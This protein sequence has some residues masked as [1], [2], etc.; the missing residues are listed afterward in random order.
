MLQRGLMMDRPLLISAIIEHAAAQFGDTTIVSRETHGPIFR[1]TYAECAVRVRRLGERA[2]A[3]RLGCRRLGGIHSVEQSSPFG[4]LLRGLRQRHGDAH[5]Q[6][7]PASGPTDL[8]HQPCRRPGGAVRR[9][10]RAPGEGNCRPLP[11]RSCLGGLER[12]GEH[13][14][15]RRHAQYSLLRRI[16]RR[17]KRG[18]RMA[19]IR[20]T[21]RRRALLHLGNDRES[22]GRPVFAPLHGAERH[23]HLHARDTGNFFERIGFADR[24][25]VSHQWLVHSLCRADR[26]S[27]AGVARSA[28][29]RRLTA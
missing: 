3:P 18:F 15:R 12:R 6:S 10:V 24:A 23:R 16:D 29:G 21:Y 9:H 19:G 8:H 27:E 22:Q 25:D 5:L 13:A 11:E 2:A 4:G 1:Y 17:A 7:A 14:R 26:R 28:P 20:R